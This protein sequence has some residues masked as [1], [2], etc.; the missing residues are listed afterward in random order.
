MEPVSLT[1]CVFLEFIEMKP[2]VLS[3][4]FF[5]CGLG[6]SSVSRDGESLLRVQRELQSLRWQ[7]TVWVF[8]RVR[9]ISIFYHTFT[10]I[11]PQCFT[12]VRTGPKS[13]QSPF[14]SSG[15]KIALP[16]AAM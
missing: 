9:S 14:C 1:I 16:N 7:M 3:Q 2:V 4:A 5:L 13:S 11:L 12:A 8:V 10:Y 15:I 6:E